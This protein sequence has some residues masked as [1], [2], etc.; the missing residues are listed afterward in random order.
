MQEPLSGGGT[1]EMLGAKVI[2]KLIAPVQKLKELKQT[3]QPKGLEVNSTLFSTIIKKLNK[4]LVSNYPPPKKTFRKLTETP[5]VQTLRSK[6]LSA[7]TPSESPRGSEAG[8]AKEVWR[9]WMLGIKLVC[10]GGVLMT[11][12][13]FQKKWVA[14]R[15]FFLFLVGVGGLVLLFFVFLLF[16]FGRKSLVVG[17]VW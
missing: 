9:R 11:S 17:K 16:F 13:W 12:L 7:P 3:C 1:A 10:T 15:F 2:W 8:L 4:N 14:P 6:T 5:S